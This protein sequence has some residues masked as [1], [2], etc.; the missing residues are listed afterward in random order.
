M[1]NEPDLLTRISH[2]V[3]RFF[4]RHL[5][6]IAYA[7]AGIAVVLSVYFVVN[8][9]MNQRQQAAEQAF[10]KVYTA[11]DSI[12]NK[13]SEDALPELLELVDSFKVVIDEHPNT[14]AASKSGYMAG[15][16]LYR[17]GRFEEALDL[18]TTAAE[19]RGDKYSALLAMQ[20]AA[21]SLEQLSRYEEAIASYKT[22]LNDYPDSF[23]VP[24]T[25]YSLG[26]L[27]EHLGMREEARQEY[28]QVVSDFD[29]SSWSELSEK[30]LLVLKSTGLGTG[31]HETGSGSVETSESAADSTEGNSQDT[32]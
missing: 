20:G 26:Q 16:I 22:L 12:E 1:H 30:K 4:S 24:E 15:N 25:H 21:N 9:V 5:K 28:E 32:D 27:Y 19:V 7:V 23:L 8:A 2:N 6:T 10:G 13:D 17:A 18:Y 3:E 31:D 29:W 11:Y 14:V